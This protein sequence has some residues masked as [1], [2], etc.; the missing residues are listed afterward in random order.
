MRDTSHDTSDDRR[1][2]PAI[3]QG[4]TGRRAIAMFDTDSNGDLVDIRYACTRHGIPESALR[5]PGF[6]FPDYSVACE[7]AD[8]G[9]MI[10]E[11]DSDE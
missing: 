4:N 10:N 7:V 9:D 6:D 1:R 3:V 11:V 2:E 5:W 8:C